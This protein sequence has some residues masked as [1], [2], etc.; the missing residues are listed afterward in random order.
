MTCRRPRTRWAPRL[1]ARGMELL[2]A[3]GVLAEPPTNEHV[4]IAKLLGLPA[5][6]EPSV[7]HNLFLLQTY[8]FA[9][10]YL[11]AEG[12]MGGEAGD[13]IAGFW[14]A[15]H[16]TPPTEPDHLC[17]LLALYVSLAEREAAE[18]DGASRVLVASARGALLHE[19][20]AS[21]VFPFLSK[22]RELG[23]D[24]YGGWST[25]LEEAILAEVGSSGHPS[26][27]PVHL[28]EAPDLPDPRTDGGEAFLHG[29]LAPARSGMIVT[30]GDLAAAARRLGLGLRMGERIY[31][32]KALFSQDAG[33]VLE[34]F[35][36]AAQ[37]WV[38]RHEQQGAD[39]GE[40]ATFWERRARATANLAMALLEDRSGWDDV[41]GDS[42]APAGASASGGQERSSVS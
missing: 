29:L 3:L 38:R 8:P 9:S 14:R 37:G 18:E 31:I 28:R 23:G 15:L 30:R 20:L 25:M 24:F 42:V 19:H 17:S 5:P 40:I 7:Y 2:R 32:L 12:M 6:P 36:D 35:V 11:G 27:L 13:R 41:P 33:K 16:M 10:V 1:R 4:R 21:W 39:L 22:V 26:T 34:W